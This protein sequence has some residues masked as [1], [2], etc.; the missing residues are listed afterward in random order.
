LNVAPDAASIA[1]GVEA[2]EDLTSIELANRLKRGQTPHKGFLRSPER[3][4]H[5]GAARGGGTMRKSFGFFAAVLLVAVVVPNLA[6]A[7]PATA[8]VK[9]AVGS[10]GNVPA[11]CTYKSSQHDRQVLTVVTLQSYTLDWVDQGNHLFYSC[12]SG[13]CRYEPGRAFY[14]DAG[15]TVRVTV[16][17]GFVVVREVNIAGRS[18]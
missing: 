9:C 11:S 4:G 12:T 18:I 10:P 15:T 16:T 7:A 5:D 17:K 8:A 6:P 1:V 14:A 2:C 13:A 3:G